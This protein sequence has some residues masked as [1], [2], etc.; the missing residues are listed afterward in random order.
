M[1]HPPMP[2]TSTSATSPCRTAHT[3]R[4]HVGLQDLR[5]PQRRQVQRG[6]LPHLVLRWHTNN[7]W[8]IGPG[9]ALDPGERFIIIP[10]MLGNGL[11]SSPSN[12]PA[13]Y[14]GPRFPGR[15][16]LRPG[17]SSASAGHREIRH[18]VDRPRHRMV[19]GC[20]ADVSVGRQPPR[21]GAAGRSVLRLQR[22]S[23]AQ[24]VFLE[25]LVT[26]LSADAAFAVATLIRQ[27]ADQGTTGFC[28]RLF[29]LGL[30][31]GVLLG[32]TWREL[33][34]TSLDDFCTGSGRVYFRDGRDPIQPDRDDRHLAQRERREHTGFGGDQKKALASIL[35]RCSPCPRRR[36]CTSRRRTSS[37]PVSSI[38][39]GEVRVIPGIWG[40]FAGGG[41]NAVDTD[42]IDAG[43]RELLAKP[44][45]RPADQPLSTRRC[46]P[47]WESGWRGRPPASGRNWWPDSTYR[48]PRGPRRAARCPRG[49]S[50]TLP[51]K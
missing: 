15:H 45:T 38:P 32:E 41:S 17:R 10:N 6:R 34:Y 44:V 36:T 23:P 49:C 25:S 9:R 27:A 21:D 40:H 35:V 16:V 51:D 39:Q 5:H 48:A 29:G 46:W 2:S 26:A 20:R 7:E 12:T 22:D 37:G 1:P 4:C 3:S 42:F 19:D 47:V 13:P 8:L 11:S 18:L 50:E 31:P 33:G 28:P 30:L 14:D 24:Q 43:L